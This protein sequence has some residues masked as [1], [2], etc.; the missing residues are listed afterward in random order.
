MMDLEVQEDKIEHIAYALDP[1]KIYL[2]NVTFP[3]HCPVEVYSD[4]MNAVKKAFNAYD[5]KAV[6]NVTNI[7]KIE[8]AEDKQATADIKW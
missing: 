2:I 3:E 4:Y 8:I 5:I 1:N 7:A 6:V